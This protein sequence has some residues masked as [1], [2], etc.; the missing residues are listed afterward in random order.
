M[1]PPPSSSSNLRCIGPPRLRLRAGTSA[2]AAQPP[3]TACLCS[4]K[5]Y[6][7]RPAGAPRR[8][9]V[10]KAPQSEESRKAEAAVA[11]LPQRECGEREL[12]SPR[13]SRVSS[14]H[15]HC[16]CRCHCR[17]PRGQE[18]LITAARACASRGARSLRLLRGRP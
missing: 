12:R 2:G 4:S 8:R 7:E 10:A 14:E 11:L 16:H 5:G 6:L 17:C 18:P 15:C 13:P 9:C 1:A 3:S